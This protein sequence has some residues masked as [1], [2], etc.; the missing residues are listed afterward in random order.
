M[1]A[2]VVGKSLELLKEAVPTVSR[3]AVLWNPDNAVFQAQM[4]R[5]TQVAAGRLGVELRIFAARGPD[6]I[7]RALTA[8]AGESVGALLV[9]A[10]PILAIHGKRIVDFAAERRLPAMYG[11]MD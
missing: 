6:E 2:E 7:D 11:I 10:D 4:L 5:E 1:T 8:I 3:V 9:L